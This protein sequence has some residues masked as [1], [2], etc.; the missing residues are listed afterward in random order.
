MKEK[1]KLSLAIHYYYYFLLLIN[2]QNDVVLGKNILCYFGKKRAGTNFLFF[3]NDLLLCLIRNN[4]L[5][6]GTFMIIYFNTKKKKW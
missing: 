5:R 4:I 6:V 2:S 1:E 3:L